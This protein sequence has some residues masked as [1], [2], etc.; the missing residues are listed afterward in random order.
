MQNLGLD[1]GQR[2]AADEGSGIREYAMG[3]KLKKGVD[4]DAQRRYNVCLY[5]KITQ[6]G[7]I[8]AQH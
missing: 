8:H 2:V 4:F 6:G 3:K 1:N 5:G 7:E